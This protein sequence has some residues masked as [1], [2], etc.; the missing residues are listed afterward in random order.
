MI[1]RRKRQLRLHI[2][3]MDGSLQ[4]I[5][6]GFWAGHYVLRLPEMLETPERSLTLEGRDVKIPRERVLFAQEL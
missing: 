1:P 2:E 6:I 4:G 3:G 5:F